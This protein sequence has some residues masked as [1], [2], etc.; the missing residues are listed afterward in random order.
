MNLKGHRNLI[1]GLVE[2]QIGAVV[3]LTSQKR[4]SI[5]FA[6]W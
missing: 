5:Y 4:A 3:A 1:L 6:K 2:P